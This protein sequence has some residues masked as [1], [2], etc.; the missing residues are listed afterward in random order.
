MLLDQFVARSEF[1]LVAYLIN[2]PLSVGDF[3][4]HALFGSCCLAGQEIKSEFIMQIRRRF[5]CI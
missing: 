4:S 2:A 5:G 3:V 1:F